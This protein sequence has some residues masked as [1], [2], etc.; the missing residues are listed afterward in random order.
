MFRFNVMHVHWE[1]RRHCFTHWKACQLATRFRA[2]NIN[3][4]LYARLPLARTPPHQLDMSHKSILHLTTITTTTIR[5]SRP[6]HSSS[7]PSFFRC[8]PALCFSFISF[9]IFASRCFIFSRSFWRL[10]A[11]FELIVF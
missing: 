2:F 1:R 5:P 10:S 8:L 4:L 6:S 3:T 7:L 9:L 11:F